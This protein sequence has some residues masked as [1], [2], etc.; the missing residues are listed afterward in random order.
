MNPPNEFSFGYRR[1]TQK[2]IPIPGVEKRIRAN[3][4]YSV[5]P[6]PALADRFVGDRIDAMRN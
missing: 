4:N 3:Q 6:P 1:S 2:A 5:I